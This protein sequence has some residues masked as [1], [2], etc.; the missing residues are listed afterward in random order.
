MDQPR[1]RKKSEIYVPEF[2]EKKTF[3]VEKGTGTPLGDIPYLVDKIRNIKSSDRIL[4]VELHRLFFARAGKARTHAKNLLQFSGFPQENLEVVMARRKAKI[5]KFS[6]ALIKRLMDLLEINR[7]AKSFESGKAN[8]SELAARFL[9][10]ISAPK[11]NPAKKKKAKATKPKKS[12]KA[13]TPKAKNPKTSKAKKKQSGKTE[14]A[15]SDAPAKNNNDA[16]DKK[17][18]K[19]VATKKAKGSKTKKSTPRKRSWF[20]ASEYMLRGRP[21]GVPRKPAAKKRKRAV[22]K[23]GKTAVKK[24]KIE[25]DEDEPLSLELQEIKDTVYAILKVVDKT[26]VTM[27]MVRK[28]AEEK[29]GKSLVQH[30]A[31]IKNMV[32]E[33]FTN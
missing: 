15:D 27:K 4:L 17:K 20:Q 22:T 9:D 8:K 24:A 32:R 16:S 7:S 21:E 31:V 33:F 18:P 5:A 23:K 11:I 25:S 29:L 28:Q 3:E 13:K 26:T 14:E 2:V 10:W 19:K 12:P 1:K 30:K 6:T